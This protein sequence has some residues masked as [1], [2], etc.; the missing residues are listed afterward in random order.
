MQ[1][2]R[3]LFRACWSMAL[4][5]AGEPTP[6]R[7]RAPSLDLSAVPDGINSVNGMSRIRTNEGLPIYLVLRDEAEGQR[8]LRL[9]GLDQHE[10]YEEYVFE[11]NKDNEK[12]NSAMWLDLERQWKLQGPDD[13]D[14]WTKRPK[15]LRGASSSNNQQ[16]GSDGDA[17]A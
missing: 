5:L 13:N 4:R 15:D 8:K 6:R 14:K 1:I 7:R 10:E 3:R 9:L 17:H 11:D 16:S 12:L 2:L